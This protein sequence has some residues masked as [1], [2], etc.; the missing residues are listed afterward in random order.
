M[1]KII[2]SL[3]LMA[4]IGFSMPIYAGSFTTSVKYIP[5]WDG[6]QISAVVMVP[7]DQG[8]GPFPLV[9]IPSSWAAPDLQNVGSGAV[10]ASQG[11]I[12]V[13]YTSRGFYDSQG[14]IDI[15]G[16]ATV[17]DVSAMIDWALINTPSDPNAIGAVGTSYGAG[18]SLLAAEL[19]P[20]IKAVAATSAWADLAASLYPNQTPSSQAMA[21]LVLAGTVTGHPGPELT[22]AT[23]RILAGDFD[24]AAAIVLP[25][26][27]ARSPITNV[28]NLNANGTAVFLANAFNDSLFAPGQLVDFYGQLSGPKQLMFSQGDHGSAE[29]AGSL[30]LP[31][32]VYTAIDRWLDHY[33]KGINNG[34]DAE[35]RVRLHS[36]SGIWHDY[37]DWAAVQ[38]GATPYYLGQ[39][40]NLLLP[41]GSFAQAP[42]TGWQSGIFTAV[43]TVASS[44]VALL[45]GFLQA[46]DFPPLASMP[47]IARAGAGVW[48]GPMYQTAQRVD[49]MSSLHVTVTPS[50]ANTTLY[51]YLYSVDLLG[52][53]QLIGHKPYSLRGAMP[54]VA[55]PIDI[56]L[57]ATSWDVPAGQRLALVI[58]TVDLR[59]A[60]ITQLGGSVTFS[61]P[62]ANPSVLSVPLH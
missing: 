48:I 60:G 51:A 3:I 56:R 16:P 11:Y 12:V 31:N 38:H 23:S 52:T 62:D 46:L 50:Q 57:E 42:S 41:T 61:S 32:E 14:L 13:G 44:G 15:A 36:Q 35:P 9:V 22:A 20:R 39:P 2:A 30:G 27:A 53:G 1:R 58:G 29:T 17:K 45:T 25:L 54:G 6:A 59:Y 37:A 5:S 19:D 26:A 28:A 47:L 10:L 4:V 43:P 34:V 24:G 21:G 18:V 49:G 33:L 55:Q 8:I 40:T 7:K